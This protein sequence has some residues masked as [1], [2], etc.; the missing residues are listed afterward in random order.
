MPYV[1]LKNL[2]QAI[3]GDSGSQH[4]RHESPKMAGGHRHYHADGYRH[5]LQTHRK[6]KPARHPQAVAT[7][8]DHGDDRH[9]EQ[10]PQSVAHTQAADTPQPERYDV[11]AE[12]GHS[13]Y[14][15]GEEECRAVALGEDDI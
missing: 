7:A 4:S 8:V 11:Q 9:I 12:R 5:N 14:R 10:I 2:F 3:E 6:N 15:L 13:A 1:P